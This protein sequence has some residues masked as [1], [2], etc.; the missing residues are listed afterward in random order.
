MSGSYIIYSG[1]PWAINYAP[2]SI[3][4]PWW[5]RTASS[6]LAVTYDLQ[7]ALD[8]LDVMQ[9]VDKPVF[10]DQAALRAHRKK[11]GLCLECGDAGEMINL[12]CMCRNGHGKVWG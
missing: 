2:A 3:V 4:N 6:T 7:K 10:V 1:G 12:A 8:A 5:N 11:E 9:R